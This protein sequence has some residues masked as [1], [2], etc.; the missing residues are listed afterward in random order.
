LADLDPHEGVVRLEGVAAANISAP[1]WR[2]QVALLPTE[3]VWWFNTVGEHFNTM[4]HEW[5]SLL[6][7]DQT[8]LEWNISR[9]SNG[10]KQR[11]ALLRVLCNDPKVLLLDEPTANLDSKNSLRIENLIAQL[12]QKRKIAVIWV[13]HN[14]D[15]LKRVATR[16]FILDTTGFKEATTTI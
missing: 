13:S 16:H 5:L 2:R 15:Q 3:A 14:I 12:R 1:L 11:L 8:V 4:N 6:E 7:F 10:E 9:L